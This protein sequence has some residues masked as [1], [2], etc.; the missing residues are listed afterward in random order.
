MQA[1]GWALIILAGMCVLPALFHWGM[2]WE[3][4]ERT[5]DNLR[6]MGALNLAAK[7]NRARGERVSRIAVIVWLCLAIALALAGGS[8]LIVDLAS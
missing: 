6:R 8:L 5:A 2:A 3:F 1:T 4:G 7:W